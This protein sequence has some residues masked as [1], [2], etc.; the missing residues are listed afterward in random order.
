MLLDPTVTWEC[1][2]C[3]ARHQT[4][5]PRVAGRSHPCPV[6]G[7]LSVPMQ[8]AGRYGIEGERHHIRFIERGD[9]IN[10]DQVQ[11]GAVMAVES[12]RS[13]GSHDTRVFAPTATNRKADQ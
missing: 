2:A 5:D 12:H 10:G 4:T 1:P 6:H 7:G 8:R 11:H 9:Y 3:G 13:D